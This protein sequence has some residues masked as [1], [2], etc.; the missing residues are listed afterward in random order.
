MIVEW[1]QECAVVGE[2]DPLHEQKVI[3]YIVPIN[4]TI[5]SRPSLYKH[6]RLTLPTYLIPQEIAYVKYCLH[7]ILH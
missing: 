2:M 4:Q 5:A 3:V 1:V 6:L 7:F